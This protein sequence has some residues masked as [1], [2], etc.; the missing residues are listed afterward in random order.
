VTTR[1]NNISQVWSRQ[2]RLSSKS[3]IIDNFSNYMRMVED[4]KEYYL[5]ENNFET[6]LTCG[7]MSG[8]C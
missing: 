4:I 6:V 8:L 7:G 2:V 5:C 1:E 3:V